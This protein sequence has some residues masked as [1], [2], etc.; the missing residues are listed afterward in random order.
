MINRQQLWKP[1]VPLNIPSIVRSAGEIRNRLPPKSW[2][3]EEGHGFEICLRPML[4]TTEVSGSVAMQ[5]VED[6]L[7]TNEIRKEPTDPFVIFPNDRPSEIQCI[8]TL[9]LADPARKT[10]HF[11]NTEDCRLDA[12]GSG[13]SR[14][15]GRQFR[16]SGADSS[17]LLSSCLHVSDR[18]TLTLLPSFCFR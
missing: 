17:T 16:L 9:V 2:L 1:E 4:P 13:I 5:S 8:L 15:C 3:F 6:H 18:S 14:Q 10:C 12:V 7:E 11:E